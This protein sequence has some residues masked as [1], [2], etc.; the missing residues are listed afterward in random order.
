[1]RSESALAR[2]NKFGPRRESVNMDYHVDDVDRRIL[3]YLELD[4]RNTSAPTIAKEM[5]VSPRT[6]RNRIK[7]LEEQGFIR[8]YHAD[9]D[10]ERVGRRLTSLYICN[11]PVDEREQVA[12][13]ALGISGVVNVR[14]VMGG[15][16]NLHI[17][18]VGTD[19][20][21]LT[22]IARDISDLGA[23]VED[24][25][26]VQRQYHH[27]YHHFAPDETS[28]PARMPDFRR[29]AGDAEVVDLTVVA[30]APIVGQTVAEIADRGLV[31]DD[32]LVVAIE[33]GNNVLTPNGHTTVQAGDLV[34]VVSRNG[35]PKETVNAFT[36]PQHA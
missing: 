36:K 12:R 24:E 7:R 18:A 5:D 20:S 1:M 21:D 27:P 26:L 15:R 29:L 14:E 31:G 33:R 16:G 34:T 23:T 2:G 8:G 3:Y 6:I 10:Y 25:A 19:S 32:V 11:V 35:V 30:E 9:V 4:A 22:R 28:T 13:Q 17:L